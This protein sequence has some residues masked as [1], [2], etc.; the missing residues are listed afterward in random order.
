MLVNV[1]RHLKRKGGRLSELTTH[2]A[3]IKKIDNLLRSILPPSLKG[4]IK[5]ANYANGTLTLHANSAVWRTRLHFQQATILSSLRQETGLH[6]LHELQI[7]TR[8]PISAYGLAPGEPSIPT[9]QR[10]RP[11][12]EC[13][14]FLRDFARYGTQDPRIQRSLESIATAIEHAPPLRQAE[15]AKPSSED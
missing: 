12:P 4:H 6:E 9:T 3:Q 11:G 7:K 8:P 14:R 13:V 15:S 2:C 1:N 10:P 5:V